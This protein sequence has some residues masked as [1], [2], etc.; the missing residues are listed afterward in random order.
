MWRTE[1]KERSQGST[2]LFCLVP[3][4]NKAQT[5]FQWAI[6]TH[7]TPTCVVSTKFERKFIIMQN[8]LSNQP[9]TSFVLQSHM[10][11]E[12]SHLDHFALSSKRCTN[13]TLGGRI[14]R[15]IRCWTLFRGKKKIFG[16][17]FF[18]PGG[19]APTPAQTPLGLM[20]RR[21]LRQV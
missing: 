20:H 12:I 13:I 11:W 17:N 9:R 10:D 3:M 14:L 5:Y 2:R 21:L 4:S 18:R 1:S 16:K 7:W 6:K 8:A 19:V 15:P